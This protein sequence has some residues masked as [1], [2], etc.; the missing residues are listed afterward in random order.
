MFRQWIHSSIV[1]NDSLKV[2]PNGSRYTLTPHEK[3]NSQEKPLKVEGKS[4]RRKISA[5]L[6]LSNVFTQRVNPR[7]NTT[8]NA[9]VRYLHQR[10]SEPAVIGPPSTD[11]SSSTSSSSN[12]SKRHLEIHIKPS[13]IH[14]TWSINQAIAA[15]GSSST[16]SSSNASKHH[17]ESQQKPP[18][19]Y[20][21]YSINQAIAAGVPVIITK[22]E[23]QRRRVLGKIHQEDEDFMQGLVAKFSHP[24]NHRRGWQNGGDKGKDKAR[25]VKG[26]WKGKG[27]AH[28]AKVDEGNGRAPQQ[29]KGNPGMRPIHW[30][31]IEGN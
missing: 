7:A 12:S 10:Q 22:D 13:R 25:Q 26:D 5:K 29:A 8:A 15:G 17:I 11:G 18:R 9:Y 21:T 28:Q 27:K 30:Y 2:I 6:A 23:A 14:E 3:K 24:V 4:I 31:S 19:I 20:E 16:S 1:K